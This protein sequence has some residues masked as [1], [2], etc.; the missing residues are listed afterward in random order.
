MK[1]EYYI[2]TAFDTTRNKIVY[3]ACQECGDYFWSEF[4]SRASH[5]ETLDAIPKSIPTAHGKLTSFEI[6]HTSGSTKNYFESNKKIQVAA[7]TPKKKKLECTNGEFLKL[8]ENFT[9]TLND[10]KDEFN[11]SEQDFATH[12]LTKFY[13]FI[14]SKDLEIQE[15]YKQYLE[16][17]KLF[18]NVPT[19]RAV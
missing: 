15:K 13:N 11:T 19:D 2:F 3:L 10:H 5:F 16:L 1:N 17:K 4:S 14:C 9:E 18:E 8:V 6:R 7:G 12:I